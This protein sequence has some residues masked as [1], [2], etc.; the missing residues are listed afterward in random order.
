MTAINPRTVPASKRTFG[1][2]LFLTQKNS[3]TKYAIH[4]A[5]SKGAILLNDHSMAMNEKP[6]QT[7][8]ASN[9]YFI[10]RLT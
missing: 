5:T 1:A 10:R 8:A 3:M 4:G 9:R 7:M 6:V 2:R